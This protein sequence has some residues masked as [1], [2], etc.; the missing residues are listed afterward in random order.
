MAQSSGVFFFGGELLCSIAFIVF[1][2]EK[3]ASDTL[4][5]RDVLIIQIG[6]LSSALIIRRYMYSRMLKKTAP[7]GLAIHDAICLMLAAVMYRWHE[8]RP[9]RLA[10]Q[11]TM[12]LCNR[13]KG[14]VVFACQAPYDVQV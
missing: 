11:G 3:Q 5:L 7:P 1:L 14:V 6:E 13:D 12:H 4:S 10:S 2:I 9:R 8:S